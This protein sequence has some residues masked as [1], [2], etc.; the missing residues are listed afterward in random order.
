MKH[1]YLTDDPPDENSP[2]A[3][4]WWNE[5]SMVM[6]WLWHSMEPSVGSTVH[7]LDIAKKIWN[8]LEEMYSH[9]SNVSQIYQISETMFSTKQDASAALVSN[10]RGDSVRGGRGHGGR[11]SAPRGGREGREPYQ[12]WL[13][14]YCGNIGHIELFLL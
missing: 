10:G 11:S 5:M 3:E 2:S 13:C 14:D 6:T 4:T 8:I 9:T 7:F 1:K 12:N